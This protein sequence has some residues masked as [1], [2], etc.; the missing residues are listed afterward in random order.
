MSFWENLGNGLAAGAAF[1][2][3]SKFMPMNSWGFGMGYNP[4][5]SYGIFYGMGH[6]HHHHFCPPPPPMSCHYSYWC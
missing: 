6:H 2:I 4:M 5:L 3:M 1:G